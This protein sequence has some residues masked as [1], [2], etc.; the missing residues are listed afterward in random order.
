MSPKISQGG[1]ATCMGV[2]YCVTAA[3]LN[4]VVEGSYIVV[5]DP[6]TEGEDVSGVLDD[7]VYITLTIS[8][9]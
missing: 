7:P 4:T 5:N 2:S 3:A 9:A 6:F 1:V 8:P